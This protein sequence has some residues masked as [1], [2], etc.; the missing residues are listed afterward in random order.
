[1]EILGHSQISLTQ[2]TY[3]HVMPRV[4]ADATQRLGEVLFALM[5]TTMAPPDGPTP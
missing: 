1:M 5:A 2:N 4:I 3:R